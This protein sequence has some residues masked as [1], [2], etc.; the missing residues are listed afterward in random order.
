MDYSFAL[1]L[2]DVLRE[3]TKCLFSILQANCPGGGILVYSMTQCI[4]CMLPL[5]ADLTIGGLPVCKESIIVFC[6]GIP[7]FSW[8]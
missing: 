2:G 7:S 6:Q 8:D 3:C 1:H 4:R 5:P